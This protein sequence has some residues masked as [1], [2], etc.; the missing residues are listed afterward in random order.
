MRKITLIALVLGALAAVAVPAGSAANAP[1]RLEFDKT[2]TG[3][4]V[5]QGTVS[6]DV[7]GSLETRLLD[8]TVSGPVWHVTFDWIVDSGASSFTARLNGTLNT[9]TGAVVMDGN[10]ISGY[11]LGAQVHE[12]GQLVDPATLEFAGSIRVMPATA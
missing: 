10:V 4:G 11:L 1:V 5:W 12:E 8:I 9:K 2:A 3:P 6:G 7:E